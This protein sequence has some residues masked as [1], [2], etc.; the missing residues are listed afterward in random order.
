MATPTLT[1][2]SPPKKKR[3]TKRKKKR[4]EKKKRNSLDRKPLK[5]CHQLI[6]TVE[7]TH[8][9]TMDGV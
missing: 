4:K 3:K 9:Q 5:K 1:P 8:S 7:D 2:I 6:Q